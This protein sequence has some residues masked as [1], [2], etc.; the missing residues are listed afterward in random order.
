VPRF[1]LTIETRDGICPVSVVTPTGAV[2]P[3]PAVIFFMDGF[4]IRPAMWEMG[5]HLANG[6]Y[7]VLLPDLFYRQGSYPPKI[8]SQ[9]HGEPRL[10]KNLTKWASSLDRDRNIS[11]TAAFIRF[12]FT[13]PEVAGDRFGVTGYGMGGT[14]ALTVAGAF[15]DRFAA[16]ASFHGGNLATDHPDS[17]HLFV[18]NITGR[19]YIAS[20]MEDSDFPEEQKIRLARALAEAGVDHLIETFPGGRHGCAVPDVPTFDLAAAERHWAALFRLLRDTFAIEH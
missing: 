9:V 3:W 18:R 17:P 7:L 12:L 20:A 19:V 13:R 6:G 1:D 10:M 14:I 2:G 15:P 5:Q 16:V 8:P 11:D 4:G